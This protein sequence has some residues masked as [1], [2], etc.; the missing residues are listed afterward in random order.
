MWR[1]CKEF[2]GGKK[3]PMIR[4]IPVCPR[5]PLRLGDDQ[6]SESTH[7]DSDAPVHSPCPAAASR[8]HL[9]QRVERCADCTSWS[10]I[11]GISLGRAQNTLTWDR[12]IKTKAHVHWSSDICQAQ[13]NKSHSHDS[14]EHRPTNMLNTAQGFPITSKN[15]GLLHIVIIDKLVALSGFLAW[16]S[17][18]H[19][20][21]F[22]RD[23]LLRLYGIDQKHA[24]PPWP[25]PGPQLDAARLMSW[26]LHKHRCGHSSGTKEP[27]A[28]LSPEPLACQTGSVFQ[29]DSGGPQRCR[30]K[31]NE[32]LL[33]QRATLH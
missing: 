24:S 10:S 31:Q 27:N 17:G 16:V 32:C 28:T 8:S 3:P 6:K 30:L 22:F 13:R 14:Y 18:P 29:A 5:R 19:R 21:T 7:R 2:C 12:N 15:P 4:A 26:A 9:T 33:P 25:V 11:Q 20:A 23:S 1:M